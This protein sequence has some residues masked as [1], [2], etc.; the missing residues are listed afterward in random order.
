MGNTS[1]NEVRVR[2]IYHSQADIDA[3]LNKLDSCVLDHG[4]Y[5]LPQELMPEVQKLL[6][7]ADEMYSRLVENSVV[8]K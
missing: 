4:S 2:D 6:R 5:E 1:R 3:M 7:D 8:F